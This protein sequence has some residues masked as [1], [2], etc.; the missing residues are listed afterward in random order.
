M[1]LLRKSTVLWELVCILISILRR[2]LILSIGSFLPVTLEQLARE[3]GVLYSDRTTSCMSNVS[4]EGGVMRRVVEA[5]FKRAT[6]KDN[7]K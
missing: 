4:S 2:N 6:D 1:A 3:N 5:M 7:R